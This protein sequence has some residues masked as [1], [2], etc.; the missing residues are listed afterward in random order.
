VGLYAFDKKILGARAGLGPSL[1]LRHADHL[2]VDD[3]ADRSPDQ[4]VR[5]RRDPF[6]SIRQQG[7][8]RHPIERGS[9]TT[10]TR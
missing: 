2:V 7:P 4:L 3:R 6:R 8:R 9:N 10:R 5:A 1:P